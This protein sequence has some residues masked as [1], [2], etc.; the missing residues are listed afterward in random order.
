MVTGV[1]VSCM[2]LY[3]KPP[4]LHFNEM[5]AGV[6]L[7]QMGLLNQQYHYCKSQ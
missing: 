7:S 4:L 3:G 6:L 5:L 1:W 2:G